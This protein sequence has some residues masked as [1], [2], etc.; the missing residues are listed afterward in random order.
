MNVEF[1]DCIEMY[2][3]ISAAGSEI[4]LKARL[5]T[6]HTFLAPKSSERL[7]RGI[8]GRIG[9]LSLTAILPVSLGLSGHR[10]HEY[11]PA[12]RKPTLRDFLRATV[13]SVIDRI[14]PP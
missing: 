8:S 9:N 14:S 10:R 4:N 12:V 13:T 1:G 2:C 7:F 3:A 11:L 5:P 6:L